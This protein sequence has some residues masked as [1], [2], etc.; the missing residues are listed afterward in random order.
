MPEFDMPAHSTAFCK[1]HSEICDSYC[2]STLNPILNATYDFLDKYIKD[3]ASY[4][5]DNVLHLGGDELPTDCWSK[6]PSI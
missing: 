1:S 3:V 2:K 5:P 4:F 6:D